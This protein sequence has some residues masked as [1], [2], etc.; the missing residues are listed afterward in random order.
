MAVCR[1]DPAN[2]STCAYCNEE[3]IDESEHNENCINF[4][5]FENINLKSKV[6][7]LADINCDLRSQL[8]MEKD[9]SN[10]LRDNV[11]V[12]ENELQNSYGTNSIL[13]G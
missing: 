9:L 11:A 7:D 2:I 4:I 8:N 13:Q 10:E 5:K 12:L 3:Y 1:H 6:E